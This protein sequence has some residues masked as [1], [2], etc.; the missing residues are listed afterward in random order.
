M[1]RF[2]ETGSV[3]T[4]SWLFLVNWILAEG[5]QQV[6]LTLRLVPTRM[7]GTAEL[8]PSQKY[9]KENEGGGKEKIIM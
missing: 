9:S 6:S 4:N 7:K 8:L 2:E 1:F 3:N 5:V